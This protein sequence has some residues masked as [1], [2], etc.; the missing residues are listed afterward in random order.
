MEAGRLH[1]EY[2]TVYERNVDFAIE[3]ENEQVVESVQQETDELE[4]VEEE[5]NKVLAEVEILLEFDNF[6][7]NLNEQLDNWQQQAQA[8]IN[9]IL[10]NINNEWQA[11]LAPRGWGATID[12]ISGIPS[13]VSMPASPLF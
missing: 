3:E 13:P 7:Q 10:L 8:D 2:P 12:T 1:I 9:N 5:E 6:F 11:V 4:E